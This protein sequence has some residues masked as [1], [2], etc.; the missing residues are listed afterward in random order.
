[1]VLDQAA[2]VRSIGHDALPTAFRKT[3]LAIL[4]NEGMKSNPGDGFH[5]GGLVSKDRMEM[6]NS[7]RRMRVELE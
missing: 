4:C 5:S 2:G 1:M 6:T 7:Q 3:P